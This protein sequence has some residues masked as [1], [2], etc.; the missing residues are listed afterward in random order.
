MACD[1]EVHLLTSDW[2]IDRASPPDMDAL[3]G[4]VAATAFLEE[5]LAFS[6][7]MRDY[8]YFFVE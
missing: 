3:I 2:L 7:N 8:I 1:F 6:V 4:S 5:F